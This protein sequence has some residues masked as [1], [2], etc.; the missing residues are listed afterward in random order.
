METWWFTK[1]KIKKILTRDVRNPGSDMG[2]AQM[3]QGQTSQW[4][5]NPPLLISGSPIAIHI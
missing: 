1:K 5:F 4:D 2:Q 3:W